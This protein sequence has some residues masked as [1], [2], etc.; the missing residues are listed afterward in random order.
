[1]CRNKGN[2]FQYVYDDL[3]AT[4]QALVDQQRNLLLSGG[5]TVREIAH[6]KLI[7]TVDTDIADG[8]FTEDED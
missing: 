5:D 2:D 6:S 3:R 7:T 1:M 8:E 4:T